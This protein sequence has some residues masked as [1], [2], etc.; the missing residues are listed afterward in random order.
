VRATLELFHATRELR[1]VELDLVAR[2]RPDGDEVT[3][4]LD[5]VLFIW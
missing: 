1:F 2:Y 5:V 3:V 4:G